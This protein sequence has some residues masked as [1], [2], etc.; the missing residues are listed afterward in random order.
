MPLCS[1]YAHLLLSYTPKKAPS[2]IDQSDSAYSPSP[3]I[4]QNVR[5]RLAP[6][7]QDRHQTHLRPGPLPP[8][9]QPHRMPPPAIAPHIPQSSNII[10]N[11]PP[12]IILDL[13]TRQFGGQVEDFG[14]GERGEARGGVDVEF[15]HNAGGVDGADA[16]KGLQG[17]LGG[18]SGMGEGRQGKGK[19]RG[20]GRRYRIDGKL[21]KRGRSVRKIEGLYLDENGFREVISQDEDL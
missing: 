11:L 12:Q 10:P 17:F 2:E 5:P 8:N 16:E 7:R 13:H 3:S 18:F 6:P 15:G 4:T 19:R 9:R 1:H 20:L 14:R 21:A